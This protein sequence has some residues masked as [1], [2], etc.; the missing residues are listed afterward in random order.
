MLDKILDMYPVAGTISAKVGW[1]S[2]SLTKA[3][4]MV[5]RVSKLGLE[6]FII[7]RAC[8]S[9]SLRNSLGF[10]KTQPGLAK[11]EKKL[12]TWLKKSEGPLR[13]LWGTFED[14][15]GTFGGPMENL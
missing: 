4:V 11:K 8:S 9:K 3:V 1:A 6:L 5:S 13:D 7:W 15:L 12:W 14:L 10:L 2:K